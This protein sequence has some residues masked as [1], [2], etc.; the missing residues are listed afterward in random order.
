[1]NARLITIITATCALLFVGRWIMRQH[2]LAQ[3]GKLFTSAQPVTTTI[4]QVISTT[5]TLQIQD[6]SRVGSLVAGT[7]QEIFVK[8]NEMVTKGQLLA[9]LDNGKHDTAIRATKGRLMQAQAQHDYASAVYE[10]EKAL[11]DA[12]HRSVQQIEEHARI[13]QT[14]AGALMASQAEHDAANIEFENTRVKAPDDGIIIKIGVKKGFKVT[15]DLNATVLFEIARDVTKM[16]AELLIEES[17]VCHVKKGQKVS[18]T[19]DSYP[20]KT[21][22]AQIESVSYAPTVT[23]NELNYRA[24]ISVDNSSLLLRPGMTL[25]ANI[26]VSKQKQALGVDAQAFYLDADAV[27]LVADTLGYDVV[28]LSATDKKKE[29]Q[30][31]GDTKFVWIHDNTRFVERALGVGAHDTRYYHACSGITADECYLVDIVEA[32][33]MDEHYKKMF[34]GAL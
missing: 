5:G 3:E 1:M 14:A 19:V 27:N 12:G 31:E 28:S 22:T 6:R 10:R 2:T 25:H 4:R 32:G 8:E 15:T 11:F 30:R 29:E 24:T 7:V 21:F 26:K 17:D 9:L 33:K 20:L 13:L 23:K 18:F 34:R 16:E